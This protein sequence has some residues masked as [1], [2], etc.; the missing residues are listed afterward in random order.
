VEFGIQLHRKLDAFTDA[1]PTVK[2]SHRRLGAEFRRYSPILMDIFYDHI[3]ARN[4]QEF[5][6]QSLQEFNDW[7]FSTLEAWRSE[8]PDASALIAGRM[9]KSQILLLYADPGVIR[10]ILERVSSRLKR[11]N[12]IALAERPLFESLAEL[13]GDFRAFFPDLLAYAEDAISSHTTFA[14]QNW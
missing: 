14:Q 11:D 4:W 13:E 10:G 3:L 5:H 1:H 12:P 7:V 6:H 8:M 9:K 2:Q